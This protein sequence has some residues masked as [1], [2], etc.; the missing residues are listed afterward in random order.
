MKV[1][2][3]FLRSV[4]SILLIAI[5]STSLYAGDGIWEVEY[6]STF[7]KE[8][9]IDSLLDNFVNPP[10]AAR[11]AVF[12][13]WMGGMV[14]KDGITRDLEAMAEQ[15][16]GGV[17]IMQMPEQPPTP[18]RWN[19]RDYPGKVKVLSDEW[20]DLV[21]YAIGEADRLGLTFSMFICPGWS[22]A[23]GPWISPEKGL[24]KLVHKKVEVEGSGK[25]SIQVPRPPRNEAKLFGNQIPE[26][27]S[28]VGIQLSADTSD[29]YTDVAVVA[30]PSRSSGKA[31]TSDDIIDLTDKMDSKGNIT[32][33]VPGG[34]WTIMRLGVAS[35][36]GLNHPAP[37]EATG[38][39]SDRMDP[40]AVRIVYE[41]M[42]GRILREARAKGYSSFK[43]FETDSYE[44]GF[45]DFGIDFRD[46]F[47]ERRGYDCVPWLP[48]WID[49]GLVID[50][51]ELTFRFRDD[52]IRTISELTAE[53]FHGK[54]RSLADENDVEWM[55]EPYA[56]IS[57]D[58]RMMGA[59]STM[60][61]SE[62]WIGKPNSSIGPAP[63]IATLY[64]LQVVWAEAFTAESYNSAWRNDP[65]L[66]KPW[67]DAVFARGVNHFYLHGF[68]HNPFGNHLQPG[69]TMGYWGTQFNRHLTWWPYSFAWHRYLARCQFMLQQGRPVNDFLAYPPK[70]QAS[71]TKVLEAGVF[72]QVV[73]DDESLFNRL[74]VRD[75]GRI[76]VKGGGDFAAIILTPD[77]AL[78]PKALRKIREL[79]QA[80]ATLIGEAPPSYSSSLEN[81][82][83]CD[84]EIT[85]LIGEMWG[86]GGQGDFNKRSLGKGKIFV[87]SRIVDVL[88][89]LTAGPDLCFLNKQNDSKIKIDR[90]EKQIKSIFNS[91]RAEEPW[92]RANA[93]SDEAFQPMDFTHRRDGN[94][95]IYFVCNTGNDAL[96]LICDFRVEGRI[97]DLWNPVS[98]K[99]GKV[100][101]WQQQ[102][103]RTKVA[104]HFAPRQSFF[105]V[106]REKTSKKSS[107]NLVAN[108]PRRETIK[109]LTGPWGVGFDPEWGGPGHVV[110]RKQR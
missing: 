108:A 49:K 2:Y 19:F 15:G 68:T 20:F 12:W 58:W 60:P 89:M 46:E 85:S 40:E 80:G 82:P 7:S 83:D 30:F 25:I 86:Q 105:V 50:S 11:P 67:G 44:A 79:V 93:I 45:Q 28:T 56:F 38:L 16:I 87:T 99:V 72:R 78:P 106:F 41:G 76:A 32:W 47:L 110:V 23:G 98:G 34:S 53:C 52:M 64:G 63:D 65:W 91:Q 73:L 94:T 14:S 103:G 100:S 22:H 27:F 21:N 3:N 42:I 104:M 92:I 29:F 54:L 59:Q 13:D 57:L 109:E 31:V 8:E 10:V 35:E 90:I 71:A 77:M 18:L 75:D 4:I 17:M 55:T 36:N 9:R 1:K 69:F 101:S 61:G 96:D 81:Y 39:E 5:L 102:D 62:F 33:D 74:W 84:N 107:G 95:E 66:L 24:K 70:Y 48:S 43:A 51:K 37:I 88:N 97:P 6:L 26:W